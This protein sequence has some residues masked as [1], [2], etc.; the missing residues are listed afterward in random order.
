MLDPLHVLDDQ[1]LILNE[2]IYDLMC[3]RKR[4]FRLYLFDQS[5]M[6]IIDIIRK[7]RFCRRIILDI[8][9]KS[10]VTFE[11]FDL[12]DDLDTILGALIAIQSF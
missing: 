5:L 11:L 3:L 8:F 7:Q 4:N 2:L 12:L 9:E 1:L 6:E 10:A